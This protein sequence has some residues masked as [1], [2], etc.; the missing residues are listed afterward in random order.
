MSYHHTR[1]FKAPKTKKEKLRA[2]K[3]YF[4]CALLFGAIAC[5]LIGWDY[6]QQ[7][8][9]AEL[10][11]VR[12]EHSKVQDELIRDLVRTQ[13]GET[14]QTQTPLPVKEPPVEK[15]YVLGETMPIILPILFGLVSLLN[16]FMGALYAV[17][18][19]R[20]PEKIES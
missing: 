7:K 3:Q 9:Q 13:K 14:Q 12:A 20:M 11:K 8:K 18:S 10:S 17:E 4:V 5:A 16:I 6:W 19:S 15:G 2:A 1:G